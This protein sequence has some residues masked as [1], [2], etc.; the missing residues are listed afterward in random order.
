[1]VLLHCDAVCLS[2]PGDQ[3]MQLLADRV[4]F[5]LVFSAGRAAA[6]PDP[7]CFFLIDFRVADDDKRQLLLRLRSSPAPD[8]RFAPV[9]VVVGADDVLALPAS[10]SSIATRLE[11]QL[12]CERIYYE[13]A[14]YFG[15]DR[16]R[17]PREEVRNVN[18]PAGRVI[19]H[20]FIRDPL[21]GI[22][23]VRPSPAPFR[24]VPGLIET[25]HHLAHG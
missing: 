9:V 20:H 12:N 15:P 8:V 10:A 22:R 1:M 14:T 18:R 17:V 13:T 5:R 24:A 16:R 7:I 2:P 23:L 6:V 4:G 3:T 25:M 21:S 19:E 11:A